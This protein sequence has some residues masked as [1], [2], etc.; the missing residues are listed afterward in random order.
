[1][2][3]ISPATVT[4]LRPMVGF[5]ILLGCNTAMGQAANLQ[6]TEAQEIERLLKTQVDCWNR[7]DINGFMQTYWKSDKLTFSGSGK[8]TR[9]WQATLDQYKKSYPAGS[10]GK[11]HFEDL[12]VELL[13]KRVA[14]VLGRWHLDLQGEKKEGNFSLVLKK[15]KQGWKIV[16]D[17]S[18]TLEEEDEE[19][20]G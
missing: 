19:D 18:S 11:L 14:L 9:G 7:E 5:V 16:H 6:E 2:S 20:A 8:T 17:H 13:S 15:M 4:W 1:M 10:M 3:S 12:E